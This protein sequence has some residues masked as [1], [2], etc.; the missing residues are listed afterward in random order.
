METYF[1][2]NRRHWD[3]LAEIHSSPTNGLYRVDGLRRGDVWL[4]PIESD[5]LG[6][7]AGRRLLHLQCHFGMDTLRLARQ[8]AEV[9]GLDFSPKAIAKARELASDLDIDATFV[10][11]NLYDAPKAINGQFD[12]VFVSWGALCWLPDI[13]RWA[14]IVAGFLNAGG[15][16][17]LL[18]AHPAAMCLKENADGEL[19]P[20]YAYFGGAEP[21]AEDEDT[22]Y[23]GDP[24]KIV[25]TRNYAWDHPI[26]RVVN[27]LLRA[28][29]QLQFL[30]EHDHVPWQAFPCLIKVG[31]GKFM[32]PPERPSIALAYSLKAVRA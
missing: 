23:S 1:E 26:S 17:Y 10:E 12:I 7:V 16:L 5:E 18:E 2:A 27:A 24:T 15:F 21:V 6:D 9:T 11:A 19:L 32:L 4:G 3:E 25:N 20:H 22:S 14:E 8:G 31:D 28:G 30:N 13:P 29:L